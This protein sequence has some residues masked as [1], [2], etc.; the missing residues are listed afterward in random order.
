MSTLTHAAK[1]RQIRPSEPAVESYHLSNG[2]GPLT[3]EIRRAFQFWTYRVEPIP[4]DF[5]TVFRL[6]RVSA[7]EGYDICLDGADSSCD[8]PDATYRQR[9]C[10]HQR[11]LAA[12]LAGDVKG[13]AA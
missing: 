5:G 6:E 9:Q 12:Y 7:A 10:K 8:C 4:S 11:L 3:L 13:G 1:R 2:A